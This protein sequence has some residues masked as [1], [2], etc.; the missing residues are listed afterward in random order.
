MQRFIFEGRL[1]KDSELKYLPN[2]NNAVLS[3]DIAVNEGYGDYKKTDFFNC[4]VFG[5]RAESLSSYLIKGTQVICVGEIHINKKDDKNRRFV[6]N[7]I[8]ENGRMNRYENAFLWLSDAG[9]ALPSYNVTEPQIP[10]QLNEKRNLFKLE[11]QT[12]MRLLIADSH[13]GWK[14]EN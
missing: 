14:M 2:S 3:F 8:D 12:H 4:A 1:T 10:L 7:H 13:L 11:S 6:L 5:K 9:V